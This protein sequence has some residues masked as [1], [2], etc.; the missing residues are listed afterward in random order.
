[1]SIVR[2]IV[3]ILCVV[4]VALVVYGYR[5]KSERIGLHQKSL[6]DWLSLLIV[7][8]AL[9]VATL[10]F[11]AQQNERVLE[12]EDR[13]AK[14]EREIEEQ[15]LQDAMLQTYF[16]QMGNLLLH[17][18]L[19]EADR[20]D[21]AFTLA[22]A[23]SSTVIARLDAKHNRSLVRFL[24]EADLIDP[25]ESSPSILS[26]TE[27][28]RVDLSGAYLEDANFMGANLTD[29]DLS[30]ADFPTASLRDANLTDA[31]LSG[32]SFFK[33]TMDDTV[34]DGA[35]FSDAYLDLAIL[36]NAYANT[37]PVNFRDASLRS[38]Y[39][40]NAELPKAN[41]RDAD[42]RGAQLD[43]TSLRGAD[44]RGATMPN[45]SKHD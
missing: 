18:D 45:G 25:I 8:A 17:Q 34:I 13:R 15:K 20:N 31:N 43:G 19:R 27:L 5:S 33:T 38:A 22:Q 30:K 35:N 39:I 11:T 28:S 41:F 2:G 23:R 26:E 42:L 16:D 37:K 24:G 4:F 40:A 7:P 6:W 10:V 29:A 12:V 44:L 21:V 32:A 1:M 36:D 14:T 9:A 3:V